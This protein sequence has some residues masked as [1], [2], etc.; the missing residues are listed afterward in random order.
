[1][2]TVNPGSLLPVAFQAAATASEIMRTSPPRAFAAKTGWDLGV[3]LA[4]E[5]CVR[6]R[7]AAETPGIGFLGH[8]QERPGQ[9]AAEWAWA[10]GPA[11]FTSDSARSVPLCA[12]SLALLHHGRPVLGVIDA[13]FL[14]RRYHAVEGRGA[15]RGD[16][17]L[18]VSAAADLSAAVVAISEDPA[19]RDGDGR[20]PL[21][22]AA[23]RLAAA[24]HRVR[25]LGT[26]VL[27]LAWVAEGQR[28]AS[29]ALGQP[30]EAVAAGV[31]I[32]REA[33]AEVAEI[34]RAP[35]VGAA[36]VIAGPAELAA[37]LGP[38]L[39]GVDTAHCALNG[40]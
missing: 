22:L 20:R 19:G 6:S 37:R 4:V 1:M 13:P 10:L 38:L 8:E 36:A 5:C 11:D 35:D 28:D 32:A 18:A 17:R 14:D 29:V 33:G 15:Y 40:G 27:D 9:P 7:L 31:I 26:A 16:R 2:I 39:H 34:D 24:V 30:L 3:E 21:E 12:V 23:E 25:L